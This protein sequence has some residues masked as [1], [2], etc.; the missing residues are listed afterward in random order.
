[1]MTTENKEVRQQWECALKCK[2]NRLTLTMCHIA[3][4]QRILSNE[5]KISKSTKTDP[6]A[7]VRM[8]A[9]RSK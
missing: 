1:M 2:Q 7:N 5:E 3:E 8:E 4:Q 6:H 9:T